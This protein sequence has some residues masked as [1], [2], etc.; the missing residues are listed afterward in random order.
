MTQESAKRK[1]RKKE[2]MGRLQDVE[3]AARALDA[4]LDEDHPA[5]SRL[6]RSYHDK[7]FLE[8]DLP[9]LLMMKRGLARMSQAA[10]AA[11]DYRRSLSPMPLPKGIS[12]LDLFILALARDYES[13]SSGKP[14]IKLAEGKKAGSFVAF[15]QET[16]RQFGVRVPAGE[17][18][19]KALEQ[20]QDLYRGRSRRQC[21]DRHNLP[22]HGDKEVQN[23]LCRQRGRGRSWAQAHSSLDGLPRYSASG[24]RNIFLITV[25]TILP[26]ET[27]RNN[28][29]AGIRQLVEHGEDFFIIFDV[30]RGTM[31]GPDKDDEAADAWIKAA[32]IL[33]VEGA[34]IF[35]ITHSPYS[36]DTRARG[37]SHGWGSWDA[38][39]QSDGDKEKRTVILKV[40][41]IKE[42]DSS[43]QWGFTLEEQEVEE[44]PRRVFACPAARRQREGEKARTVTQTKILALGSHRTGD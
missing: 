14:A 10:K 33:I 23:L 12:P 16:A 41:R 19:Q 13:Y 42:H 39:L 35:S 30:H 1:S 5:I 15:V 9:G 26:N 43:G 38:R 34:T 29:I 40:D 20:L 28:L 32:E 17:T 11:A 2:E 25:E 18:I 27:S 31:G 36:D 22:R 8:A 21:F 24:P 37:S 44:Q 6:M 4:L 3:R 7:P